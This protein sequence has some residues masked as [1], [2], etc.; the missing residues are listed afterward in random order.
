MSKKR[1]PRHPQEKPQPKD[2]HPAN[3]DEAIEAREVINPKSP[4]DKKCPPPKEKDHVFWKWLSRAGIIAGIAYAIITWF[5]YCA[6]RDSANAARDAANAAKEQNTQSRA[7]QAA[8]L[9]VEMPA[10]EITESTQNGITYLYAKGSLVIKNVAPTPAVDTAIKSSSGGGIKLPE[11]G[12]YPA[13]LKPDPKGA[14]I[15]ITNPVEMPYN[16]LIGQKNQIV[17]RQ[18]YASMLVEVAY[19]DVFGQ[20]YSHTFCFLYEPRFKAFYHS[21]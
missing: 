16:Q 13:I 5:M 10:P 11:W 17:S 21:C 4:E 20:P 6:N 7:I 14:P 18:W 19:K 1:K 8:K 2:N 3:N 12:S 9:T 15:V